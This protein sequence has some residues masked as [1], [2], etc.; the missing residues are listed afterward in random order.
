MAGHSNFCLAVKAGKYGCH[1]WDVSVAHTMSNEFIF[2]RVRVNELGGMG[3]FSPQHGWGCDTIIN[4]E[5]VLASGDIVNAN[6]TSYNDLFQSLKGG[7]NNFGVVTRF[8]LQSFPQGPIL[9]R[10][11]SIP[12]RGRRSSAQRVRRFQDRQEL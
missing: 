11:N 1:L 6:A 2:V 3:L 7:Q 8:D 10:R 5:V 12:T 9:G 4:I